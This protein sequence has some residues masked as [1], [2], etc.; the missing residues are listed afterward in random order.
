[1]DS[2]GWA[3][4]GSKTAPDYVR[5]VTTGED[6]SQANQG[7]TRSTWTRFY[8]SDLPLTEYAKQVELRQNTCH[9]S[10]GYVAGSTVALQ[11]EA[12]RNYSGAFGCT[13][14]LLQNDPLREE[15]RRPVMR[16]HTA[17]DDPAPALLRI[18]YAMNWHKPGLE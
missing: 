5:D 3:N 13:Q 7:T 2:L 8:P 9:P 15:S 17:N 16:L 4:E 11:L 6:A 14:Q 10:Q 1:L 12:A 18:N